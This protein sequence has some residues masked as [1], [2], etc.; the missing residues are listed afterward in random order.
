MLKA[1]RKSSQGFVLV[2]A[3]GLLAIFGLMGA[4]WVQYMQLEQLESR[5]EQWQ[6][7]ANHVAQ[8]GIQAAIGDIQS[9]LNTGGVSTLLGDQQY[10]VPVY[11]TVRGGGQAP[12]AA[13]EKA[14]G[15]ATVKITDECAR[16]NVNFASTRVLRA[17]F[18]SGDMARLVRKSLPRPDGTV[19][20]ETGT[21]RWLVN[22][23]D[24]VTRN[25]IDAGTLASIGERVL[26]LYTV[27]DPSNPEAFINVNTAS[28]AVLEAVLAVDSAT[29]D[30]IVANRPFTTVDQL[31]AAA[32]KP[33]NTFNVRP[34]LATP[35]A[36][37][38]QLCFSSRCFRIVSEAKVTTPD[39]NNV[40][41]TR[42]QARAEA[43]VYF[44]ADGRPQVRFS[45]TVRSQEG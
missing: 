21:Q 26:T 34:D 17:L 16:I 6:L 8:G 36:L 28:Q 22:L 39:M 25:L 35:D 27:P 3:L 18:G 41:R 42:G 38:K 10:A 24:L 30:A 44:P 1:R 15:H 11:K 45:S 43:V 14:G 23:D 33:A 12:L 7:H 5:Q 4:A 9:A 20:D 31:V 29:A 40:P 13:D 37:P 19:D 32:G 2:L